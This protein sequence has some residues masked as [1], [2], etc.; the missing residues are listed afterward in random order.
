MRL[1]TALLDAISSIFNTS[2]LRCLHAEVINL[3]FL[4]QQYHTEAQSHL[5]DLLYTGNT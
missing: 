2:M 3:P 4:N 1:L 5:K